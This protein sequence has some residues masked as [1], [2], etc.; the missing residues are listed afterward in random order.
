VVGNAVAYHLTWF[1]EVLLVTEMTGKCK[2]YKMHF[3][4]KLSIYVL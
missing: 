1:T 2:Q 4:H 3:L